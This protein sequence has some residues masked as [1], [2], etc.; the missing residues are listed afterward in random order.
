MSKCKH[1]WRLLSEVTTESKFEHSLRV[2]GKI[3]SLPGQLAC[4]KRKHIQVVV[5]NE[6]GK[7]K[8]FVEVL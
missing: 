1:I 3:N 8:R 7:L 2:L 4:A 6:C 5:C